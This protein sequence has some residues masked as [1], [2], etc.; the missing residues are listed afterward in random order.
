MFLADA[1]NEFTG[2]WVVV[3]IA[4]VGGVG[5]ILAIAAY[6][7]TSRELTTVVNSID[8]L[9]KT[10]AQNNK[11]NEDRASEIHGRL[12][13]LA[14]R[15]GHVEGRAQAFEMAF[16]KFTRVIEATSRG[17]NETIIAFTRSLDTFATVVDR[18]TRERSNREK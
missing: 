10:L 17:S 1:S 18:S 14:E 6:F 2:Q 5:V 3:A 9:T 11:D 16:E 13:P 15:I 8:T 7:A 12:N 4:V